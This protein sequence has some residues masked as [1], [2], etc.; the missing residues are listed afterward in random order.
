MFF[1]VFFAMANSEGSDLKGFPKFI[2]ENFSWMAFPIYLLKYI[3]T[4]E[5]YMFLL[6]ILFP[7][8]FWFMIYKIFEKIIK[9]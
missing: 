3:P 1:I 9:L 2:N 7:T 8:I 6:M 5:G 4:G